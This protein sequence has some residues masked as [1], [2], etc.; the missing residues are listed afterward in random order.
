M[1]ELR[2]YQQEIIQLARQAFSRCKRVILSAPTGAGKCHGIDTEILMADG[3]I[4][5]VQ[6]IKVGDKLIGPHGEIKNVLSL[7]Y[8]YGD[9]YRVIPRKGKTYTCNA[10]HILSL[11]KV[12]G[13][14]GI[15]LK[16]G[17]KIPKE[18]DVVNVS[19]ANFI[20]SNGTAKHCLKGW[21]SDAI[22]FH[23][24]K[25]NLAI[26]PYVLGAWL[27]DGNSKGVGI[28]KYECKMIDEV[29][30]YFK[31]LGLKIR[32]ENGRG[33]KT[34]YG[35]NQKGHKNEF[36]EKLR[37]LNLEDNKHIPYI[38]KTSFIQDRMELI[39]GLLDSDGSVSNNGYD[40]ISS[41]KQLAYDFAFI[42][43]SVGLSCY[44]SQCEKSIKSIG[45]TGMYWRCSISGDCDKIPC[46]DKIVSTRLQKK[47]HLVHGIRIESIGKG[48]YF[49]F[50]LDGDGL[51]L[52]G[53]FTVTHNTAIAMHIVKSSL[54]KG[55]RIAFVVDRLTLL[56]Q[57]ARV[58][59]QQGIDYGVIQGDHPFT[60]FSKQFQICSAQTL[61]RRKASDFDFFIFDEAHITYKHQLEMLKNANG[62]YFLGLTATPFTR[63]LAKY[64]DELVWNKRTGDLIKEGY[65]SEYEAYGP[66]EPDL[67]GV[68]TVGDDFNKKQLAERTDTKKIIGNIVEHFFKFA[69]D[70][71]TVA[72]GVNTA[73]AEHIADEFNKAGIKADF[74]H[75]Y[76]PKEEVKEKLDKFR[77]GDTQ[78]LASVDMI[79]RGFDMPEADCLIVARPTKS[80]NYHLQALGRVLRI[81]EG[82]QN[83]L[84][85]DHAGNIRRLGLPDDTFE[86]KLD[87][88]N[89]KN[90]SNN[91]RM[92]EKI[93]KPCEKCF[94]LKTSHKCPKC[95][96]EP[97]IKR[98][99]GVKTEN[100]SLVQI[101]QARL[102]QA[103][104]Q[105]KEKIYA[106]LLAGSR[107][108]G[109][110]DGT[111]AHKYKE[112]FGVWPHKKVEPDQQFYEFM[113]K[114]FESNPKYAYRIY[115][116]MLQ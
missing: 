52:L 74:I 10:D 105:D 85:L 77:A 93:A 29:L 8:G 107:A 25:Q 57:T 27:G 39:A 89:K 9:M 20:A 60:D 51:Y 36:L 69:K 62:T 31:S 47:R 13:S 32:E 97:E 78:L 17:D 16:N 115:F 56:D 7:G 18:A 12:N 101:Q 66:Q 82:K 3:T 37:F 90:A 42:C 108:F 46:R 99:S 68:K 111:A 34:Y 48:E 102:R 4:K 88:G 96:F 40:W 54:E 6:D 76:L 41:N 84:I 75:C 104:P 109:W 73:H 98:S 70:R 95:G 116:S 2:P 59:Y 24:E 86:M 49:G 50:E 92:K 53:D 44:V 45:F 87:D 26:P 72:M 91:P 106:K 11:R 30:S 94:F 80:L 43:R 61:A 55:K 114:T 21:R 67:E 15:I 1:L 22:E 23:G 35:I 103:A 64:W 5:K 63:G 38:Y 71:R 113:K 65:L 110:K 83:A 81:A 100:G 28:T 33:C 58:F 14:D 79:S 112:Y 19:V